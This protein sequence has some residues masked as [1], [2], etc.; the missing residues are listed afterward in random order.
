[1]VYGVTNPATRRGA[2]LAWNLIKALHNDG[3]ITAARDARAR[4]R[5]EPVSLDETRLW[6][7]LHLGEPV[8]P[9][10][11]LIMA[12]IA[13]RQPD[14]P[15]HDAIIALLV[16]EVLLTAPVPGAPFSAELADAVRRLADGPEPSR[17]RAA[18]D[19]RR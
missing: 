14:G 12:D 3:K 16:R 15:L 7:Q 13:Q 5:P 6:M 2:D 19:V 17:Q 18:A 11:A 8:A 4:H 10:D 9:D 1:M